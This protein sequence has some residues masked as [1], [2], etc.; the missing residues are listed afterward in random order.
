MAFRL[1]SVMACVVLGLI[2]A[3]GA[4]LAQDNPRTLPKPDDKPGAANRPIKVFILMGQSNMVGMGD[5]GPESAKGTLTY[6]TK[7]DK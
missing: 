5:I 3:S 7:T 2:V 1:P 4:T 6:L